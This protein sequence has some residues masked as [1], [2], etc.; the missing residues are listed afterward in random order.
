[1]GPAGQ[2]H[3]PQ[4]TGFPLAIGTRTLGLAQADFNADGRPDLAVALP[5][6]D[7]VAVLL[8]QAGGGFASM[9]G[10]PFDVG[11]S[12]VGVTSADFNRDGAPDLAVANQGGKSIS[13]LLRTATGFANDP[14]SPIVTGQSATE[15]ATADFNADGKTDLAVANHSSNTVSVLINATPDPS[16]PPPPRRPRRISTPTT[17]A[18][19]SARLPGQRSQHPARDPGLPAGRHRPGLLRRGRGLPVLV[20]GCATRTT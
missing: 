15:I 17:T 20:A 3:L 1:M 8:G 5:A 10:S 11:D 19:T 9:S 6:I 16:P 12:P 14:S 13:V 7:K 2:R 4:G 18:R